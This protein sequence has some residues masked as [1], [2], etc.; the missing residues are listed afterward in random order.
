[1]RYREMG[2]TGVKVSV[3]GFGCMRLPTVDG[4]DSR[5]DEER[6]IK[7]IRNGI[8]SGINYVDT[9]YGYHSGNS[10]RLVG[11]ALK[12]G[13][14]DKVNL[15]TKL[16]LWNINCE[17]DVDRLLN[18]QLAKLDTDYIDFYLLHAV[19][20]DSWENKVLKF[21]VLPKL[22]QKLAEGKIRHL[23]FSFHDDLEVFKKV[24]DSYDG[25]EFCQIQF[26][27]I[28]V[29]YQAGMEGLQYAAS[30]G[31]GV[32]VME[33]LLGGKLAA[34]HEKI[35]QKL[36]FTARKP[37][38]LAASMRK[39]RAIDVQKVAAFE[40][41][42]VG[43]IGIGKDETRRKKRRNALGI[44]DDRNDNPLHPCMVLHRKRYGCRGRYFADPFT[45][46]RNT[47]LRIVANHKRI[48]QR[49]IGALRRPNPRVL[50][51][52]GEKPHPQIELTTDE[53]GHAL[54]GIR[55]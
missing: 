27:Y 17:E 9:A 23:G 47:S 24:I 42:T 8:D 18:E 46:I 11:K 54:D 55:L 53:L 4:D 19:N 12:D 33:P 22:E 20:N 36:R 29:D 6:A 1:M 32:I 3:L 34:P 41:R 15:A 35:A 40:Y 21:N 31:L 2:K 7:I 39:R 44:I 28:D 5:I 48:T 38:E 14:R 51:V 10:E 30:K 45:I 43:I 50:P 13:Y 49:F 25:F 26:N 16:P 52:D 37:H